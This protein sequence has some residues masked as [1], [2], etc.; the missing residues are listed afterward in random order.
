MTDTWDLP[1]P[2]LEFVFE[3]RVDTARELPVRTTPGREFGFIPITGGTVVGPRFTGTVVPNSGGDWASHIG[4]TWH[5]DARYALQHDDG[6][7]VEIWNKGY[8]RA[9]PEQEA[10]VASGQRVPEQHY[11]YRCAPTFSTDA[12]QHLWL[13]EHQFIG[14]LRDDSGQ[15]C[16]RIFVLH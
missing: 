4:E 8:Y 13:T 14:M 3:I 15:I 5:L 6:S 9:T 11:Y 1:K 10:R 16:I 7:T 2:T 12:P